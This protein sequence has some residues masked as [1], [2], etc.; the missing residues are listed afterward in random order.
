V[1]AV[2]AEEISAEGQV[3]N[4]AELVGHFEVLDDVDAEPLEFVR[5]IAGADA[6]HQSAIRQR[7]GRGNLG[8]EP[9]R[10]YKGKTTTAVPSRILLVIEAQCATIIN[11]DAHRQ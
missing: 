8:G 7:V 4:V 11:G 3:E 2:V 1:L 9:S 10:L 6:E 5:L